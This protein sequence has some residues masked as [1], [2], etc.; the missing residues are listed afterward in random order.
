MLLP[1]MHLEMC[2]FLSPTVNQLVNLKEILDIRC[3][4]Y[5]LTMSNDGF[6]MIFEVI[7]QLINQSCIKLRF[8]EWFGLYSLRW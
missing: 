6:L 2:G 1:M 8:S 3:M 7:R 4:D 5:V